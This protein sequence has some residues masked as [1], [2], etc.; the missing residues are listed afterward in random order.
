MITGIIHNEPIEIYHASDATSHSKLET[1]RDR[2]RGTLKYFAQYVAKTAAPRE[3]KD[4]YD[5]G[6]G[7][8]AL[9]LEGS[10]AYIAKTWVA[11]KAKKSLFYF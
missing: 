2:D 9:L 11:L 7:I 10:D 1:L 8:D 3:H 4:C 6:N 5:V